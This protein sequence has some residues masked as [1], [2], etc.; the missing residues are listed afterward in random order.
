MAPVVEH[1]D[2][3]K[4]PQKDDS[5]DKDFTLEDDDGFEEFET[6]DVP[7]KDTLQVPLLYVYSILKHNTTRVKL[8]GFGKW[9]GTMKT[10]I[11]ISQRNWKRN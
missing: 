4:E 5:T 8:Q 9:I 10:S 11:L 3:G 7:E 6:G 1:P 2:G